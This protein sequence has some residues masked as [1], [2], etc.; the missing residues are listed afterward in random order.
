M[1]VVRQ[2]TLIFFRQL[3]H[4]M[5]QFSNSFIWLALHS[6]QYNH[7]DWHESLL[8]HPAQMNAAPWIG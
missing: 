4:W 1:G 7:A 8:R 5:S 6:S 2:L 3:G